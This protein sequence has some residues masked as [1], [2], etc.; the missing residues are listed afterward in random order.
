MD[1]LDGFADWATHKM[2]PGPRFIPF[3]HNININKG[4]LFFIILSLMIYYDNW[5]RG[6]W[7]YLAMHSCYGMFWVMKDFIFPDTH[8]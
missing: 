8:H 3:N 1:K 6:C 4:S 7:V 2:G 5:E